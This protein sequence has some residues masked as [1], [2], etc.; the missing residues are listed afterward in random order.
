MSLQ[1]VVNNLSRIVNPS[2]KIHMKNTKTQCARYENKLGTAETETV[3]D[4]KTNSEE[5]PSTSIV[6]Q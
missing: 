6:S 4:E 1:C 2:T 5:Q 3:K